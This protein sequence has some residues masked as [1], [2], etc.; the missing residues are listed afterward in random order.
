M[1]R[2]Y[3]YWALRSVAFSLLSSV[4]MPVAWAAEEIQV[5]RQAPATVSSKPIAFTTFQM[6]EQAVEQVLPCK[7]ISKDGRLGPSYGNVRYDFLCKGG[8]FATV[9][10]YLDKADTAGN[11]VAKVR[12]LYRD[13]PV[14]TNPNAGE[15]LVAQQFL[16]HVA[17]RFVPAAIAA[18]VMDGF[19]G[20]RGKSWRQGGVK[21]AFSIDKGAQFNVRRLEVEGDG[22]NLSPQVV[23]MYPVATPKD[24]GL[25]RVVPLTRDTRVSA[26]NDD[27]QVQERT[28]PGVQPAI[29]TGMPP[30]VPTDAG[31]TKP[32][33]AQAIPTHGTEIEILPT[34]AGP[35]RS[36]AI[37]PVT[38]PG[39]T[40]EP[41]VVLPVPTGVLPTPG[42][43]AD[44]AGTPLVV[45]SNAPAGAKEGEAETL[46]PATPAELNTAP[47]PES[48]NVPVAPPT[49]AAKL[50]PTTMDIIQS[51]SQRA[52]SNFDAY[53]RAVELTKDTEQK[54][55]I[56]RV[57]QAK[58]TA[59][60]P[61][62]PT[63]PKPDTAAALKPLP[64]EPVG[65][66]DSDDAQPATPAV[67]ANAAGEGLGKPAAAAVEDIGQPDNY[68]GPRSTE[69]RPLPQLKFV[70]KA[71]PLQNPAGVIQFEDEKSKL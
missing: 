10:L 6:E 7:W 39:I 55:Q 24:A 43:G 50:V 2:T 14:N 3:L 48:K 26:H 47:A 60:K 35:E 23:P 46:K 13:W 62:T 28:I 42:T 15:A 45:P 70:P 71:E 12:L 22:T 34:T 52:P 36:M 17:G 32:T 41:A 30:R 25:T 56:T 1:K 69:A 21:I 59:S 54:A 67:P 27:D 38:T 4:A 44:H 5:L 18:E 33:E 20:N 61:V 40:P 11:G 58:V 49:P 8:D 37:T 51:G 65:D 53:N 29:T 19:W 63:A 64:V 57:D 66:P 68:N 16:Q 9:S 31:L